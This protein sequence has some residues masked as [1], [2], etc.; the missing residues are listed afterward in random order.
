MTDT[1]IVV[2]TANVTGNVGSCAITSTDV[3]K[4]SWTTETIAVNSCTG[5]VVADSTY[6]SWGSVTLAILLIVGALVVIFSI[7]FAV[8]GAGDGY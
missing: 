3:S 6:I 7:G 2:P 1:N 4:S 5:A 8:S